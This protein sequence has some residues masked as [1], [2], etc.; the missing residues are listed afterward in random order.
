MGKIQTEVVSMVQAGMKAGSSSRT[1]GTDA[2][3]HKL[4]KE[5]NRKTDD[6]RKRPM[7]EKKIQSR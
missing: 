5:Q 3:F 4:L 1:S 6:R 7:P 2:A